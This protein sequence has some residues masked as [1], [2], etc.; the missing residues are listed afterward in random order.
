VVRLPGA[1]LL[2]SRQRGEDGFIDVEDGGGADARPHTEHHTTSAVVEHVPHRVLLPAVVA[3][4]VST[5]GHGR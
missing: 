3:V 5:H 2:P 4:V 1:E